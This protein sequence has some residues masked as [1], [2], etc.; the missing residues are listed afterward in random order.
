M[1]TGFDFR[2]W[3]EDKLERARPSAGNEWTATCPSCGK[4]GGFY[5][6]IDSEGTGPWVCFKCTKSGKHFAWLIVEVEGCSYADALAQMYKGAVA[7]APRKESTESLVDR[8]KGLRAGEV[9]ASADMWDGMRD[10]SGGSVDFALPKEFKSVWNDKAK[11]WRVPNYLTER[12]FMRETLKAWGVGY[13]ERCWYHAPGAAKPQKMDNRVIIPVEC[14]NGRSFTAR[15]LTGE[16]EPKYMNPT[17]ADHALLLF[18]WKFVKPGADF[19]IV[20]GPLDAMK[21]QQWGIPA[22][23]FGGK[24]LSSAQLTML[25]TYPEDTSVTVMLDPDAE[26]ESYHVASQLRL[27]FNRVFVAKIPPKDDKGRK[28]DPGASTK[29]Q[30]HSWYEDAPKFTGERGPRTRALVSDSIAKSMARFRK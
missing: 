10:A 23:A 1:A 24:A 30:A 8:I 15:D 11:S 21:L 27:R 9:E 29:A 25:F 17:G 2:E 18:G 22:L 16:Q 3:V 12:R 28:L 7:F 13:V 26:A 4:F 19:A 5:V 14:P 20:E 6:N